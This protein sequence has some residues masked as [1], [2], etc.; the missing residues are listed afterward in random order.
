MRLPPP[1]KVGK[2]QTALHTKAK[3]S[4]DYRFYALYDKVYRR[5]VLEWA[6]V[7]CLRNGGVPGVDGQSFDDIEKLGR[8]QWLDEL[9]AEL[10]KGNVPTPAGAACV[11]PESGW[12]A[13][14]A[15]HSLHQGPCGTDGYD[16]GLGTDFRGRLGARTTRLSPGSQRPGRRSPSRAAAQDGAYRGG[17][18][19]PIPCLG[20]V[21]VTPWRTRLDFPDC[22]YITVSS[23]SG[24]DGGFRSVNFN[25][26]RTRARPGSP[27]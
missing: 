14:T 21:D 13:K 20:S 1:V 6:F 24:G 2:L 11:H 26:F 22:H 19:G 4:P 10:R 16:A 9:A 5:D 3:N 8:D 17:G 7:R 23:P 27:R 12:Q 18:R 15:G 25:A